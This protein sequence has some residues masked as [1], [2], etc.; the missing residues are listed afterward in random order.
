MPTEFLGPLGPLVVAQSDRYLIEK[1]KSVALLS[2]ITMQVH[3]SNTAALQHC[4][5]VA[6]QHYGAAAHFHCSIMALG[7]CKAG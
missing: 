1:S 6:L 4:S 3:Q 2:K 5:I 7:H